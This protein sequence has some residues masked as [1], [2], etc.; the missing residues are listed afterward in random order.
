MTNPLRSLALLPM[1]CL[2][3]ACSGGGGTSTSPLTT[4]GNGTPSQPATNQVLATLGNAFNPATLT[5]TK[6]TEVSFSFATTHNVTFAATAGAPANIGD[7]STGTVTRTFSTAGTFN[8]QC[9]I[10][11]GMTGVVIVN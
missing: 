1:L 8:Y 11:S 5:V 2:V 9:T 10:H 3:A 6:G 7:T 4:G